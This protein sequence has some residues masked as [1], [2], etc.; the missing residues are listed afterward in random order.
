MALLRILAD[1]TI[2]KLGSTQTDT[3]DTV[4]NTYYS[5][6][7]AIRATAPTTTGWAVGDLW[8]D[9][10]SMSTSVSPV[11]RYWTG[12]SFLPTPGGGSTD[13]TVLLSDDFTGSDGAGWNAAKWTMGRN[14]ASGSG[15]N[16]TLLSGV[17]VLQTSTTS[18]DSG[19]ATV[20]RKAIITSTADSNITLAFK[21]D[22]TRSYFDVNVRHDTDQVDGN[23]CYSLRLQS[24][25]GGSIQTLA[26]QIAYNTTPLATKSQSFTAGTWY[27]LR[28]QVLGTTV[29]ARTWL[30][31][32]SEPG[33]W[34]VSVTDSTFTAAGKVGL[35]IRNGTSN[36]RVFIDDFVLRNA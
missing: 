27:K 12:S 16:A 24:A 18:P 14:A 20:A 2:E 23:N 33:T 25:S 36:G 30:Q 22:S 26:K 19:A 32:A 34:D 10:S 4:N 28:F 8:L 1:G 15:G 5:A 13:T 11:I 29:R 9:T 21:F 3:G 35:C 17:G 7:K 6:F 31:S